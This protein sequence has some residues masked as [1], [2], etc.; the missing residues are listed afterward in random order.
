MKIQEKQEGNLE[1]EI[2]KSENVNGRKW[3]LENENGEV[4][5]VIFFRTKIFSD[6]S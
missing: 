3:D 4:T 5:C 6:I 2:W 1:K